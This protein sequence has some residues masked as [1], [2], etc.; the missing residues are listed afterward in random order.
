VRPRSNF[1]SPDGLNVVRSNTAIA[2]RI[3]AVST[4]LRIGRKWQSSEGTLS[5]GEKLALG[6]IPGLLND[7]DLWR[8]QIAGLSSVATCHV[9]DITKSSTLREAAES[10]LAGVRSV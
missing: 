3:V 4:K 5:R 2:V 8:D 6:L 9:A 10:V 7:A 1:P